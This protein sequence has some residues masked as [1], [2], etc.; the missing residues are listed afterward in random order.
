MR[1]EG[2]AGK[3][4]RKKVASVEVGGQKSGRASGGAS[5][6]GGACNIV[7]LADIH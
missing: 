6:Q 1:K 5:L 7:H 3:R 4:E 2:E